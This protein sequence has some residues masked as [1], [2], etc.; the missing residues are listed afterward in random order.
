M[1]WPK[2]RSVDQDPRL[3]LLDCE[4]CRLAVAF[5]ANRC[6]FCQEPTPMLNRMV[7]WATLIFAPICLIIAKLL[8]LLYVAAG[9]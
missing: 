5:G 7:F 9:L 4:V 3:H 6:D 1:Y 2:R 8:I